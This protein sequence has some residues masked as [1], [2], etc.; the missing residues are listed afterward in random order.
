MW[1]CYDPRFYG[2][3]EAEQDDVLDADGLPLYWRA[4]FIGQ[5]FRENSFDD[6]GTSSQC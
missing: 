1:R 5:P 6:D 4:P 3:K 2:G